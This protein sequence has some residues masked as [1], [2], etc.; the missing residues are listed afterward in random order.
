MARRL[1]DKDLMEKFA[2]KDE[3]DVVSIAKSGDDEATLYLFRKY[4]PVIRSI[5]SNYFF[6]GSDR[7]DVFQEGMFGFY[8]AIRDFN[9]EKS[10]SFSQFA[11]LCVSRQIMATAKKAS[12]PKHKPLN[13]YISLDKYVYDENDGNKTMFDVISDN[14]VFE[15]DK[16]VIYYELSQDLKKVIR[17]KL[18]S[19]E[20]NVVALHL[21][22]ES[23]EKI[24]QVL[25]CEVKSV[26]NALQRA[27]KKIRNAALV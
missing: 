4:Y 17:D 16:E 13:F 24:A 18:S 3:I 7:E 27:R 25:R 26:D 19:F 23:Y 2:D 11:R 10:I 12:G 20:R 8:K 21:E 1:I 6:M 22:S 5:A 14:R 9:Q 15:P